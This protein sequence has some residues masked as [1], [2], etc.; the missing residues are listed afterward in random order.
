VA[1]QPAASQE[2]LSSMELLSYTVKPGNLFTDTGFSSLRIYFIF[3]SPTSVG[4]RTG[5]KMASQTVFNSLV[6]NSWY[7]VSFCVSSDVFL[8]IIQRSKSLACPSRSAGPRGCQL[9]PRILSFQT[10]SILISSA[11]WNHS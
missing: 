6:T 2:G 9:R 8:L 7:A 11:D 10:L 5:T 3:S 4:V 1:A